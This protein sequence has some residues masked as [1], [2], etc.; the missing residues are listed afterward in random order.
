MRKKQGKKVPRRTCET[1]TVKIVGQT[2]EKTY[3]EES[4]GGDF[5][6]NK[7]GRELGHHGG[8]HH[9]CDVNRRHGHD[10]SRAGGRAH[11][12]GNGREGVHGGKHEACEGGGTGS[13]RHYVICFVE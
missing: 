6:G 4:G 8:I 10:R 12:S 11:G 3:R 5:Q 7:L 13:E 2:K 9:G 1:S